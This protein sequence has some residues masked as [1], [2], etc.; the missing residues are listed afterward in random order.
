M[1]HVC[2]NVAVFKACNSFD[3]PSILKEQIGFMY[4]CTTS[5]T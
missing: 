3:F 5:W 1:K 2:L 4:S